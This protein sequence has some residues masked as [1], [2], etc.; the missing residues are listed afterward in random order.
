MDNYKETII[1]YLNHEC[2]VDELQKIRNLL[3]ESPEF[4]AELFEAEKIW[5]INHEI[6]C[7]DQQYLTK[8]FNI[9]LAKSKDHQRKIFKPS[10]IFSWRNM[11]MAASIAASILLVFIMNKKEA[12]HY[13]V[14]TVPN[15]QYSELVLSDGTKVTLNSGSELKYPTNLTNADIRHVQL[16]GEAY[17]QVKHNKAH[18]FIVTT[19]RM[20]IRVLGTTFNVKSYDNEDVEVHLEKGKVEAECITN[21]NKVILHPNDKI[22]LDQND[23]FK[24]ITSSQDNSSAWTSRNLFY[25]DKPLIQICKDLSRRYDIPIQ[26]TDSELSKEH[27]TCHITSNLTIEEVLSLLK[28]TKQIDFNKRNGSIYIYKYNHRKE[29]K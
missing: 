1:K 7:S 6:E 16:K 22:I 29:G 11:V 28:A 14:L 9:L 13:N 26:I 2:S 15:G 18:Q 24:L 19:K 20:N 17:F 25:N 5:N 27:F 3:K 4:Q 8:K 10:T 23:H 12:I 21:H